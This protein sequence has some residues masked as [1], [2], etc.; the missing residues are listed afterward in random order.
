MIFRK[1]PETQITIEIFVIRQNFFP[2]A[3]F[4]S[5][6][7]QEILI[8]DPWFYVQKWSAHRALQLRPITFFWRPSLAAILKIFFRSKKFFS[9]NHLKHVEPSK[10]SRSDEIFCRRPSL[11]AILDKKYRYLTYGSVCKNDQLIEL[12]NL[13]E[14]PW[15]GGGVRDTHGRT[16]ARTHAAEWFE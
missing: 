13:G 6:F 3:I 16:D 7:G 12:Y 1:S 4:G 15:T 5:H 14:K 9:G 2:A 8:F 10:F 11:A